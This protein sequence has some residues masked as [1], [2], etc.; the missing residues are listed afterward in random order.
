[1]WTGGFAGWLVTL[2]LRAS[3]VRERCTASA[4]WQVDS[5]WQHHELAAAFGRKAPRTACPARQQAR[6]GV[7][8]GPRNRECMDERTG[9]AGGRDTVGLVGDAGGVPAAASGCDTG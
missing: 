1:M 3:G 7:S 8:G 2:A 9:A 6:G 4:A 5:F